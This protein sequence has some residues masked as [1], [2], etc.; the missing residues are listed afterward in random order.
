MFRFNRNFLTRA[1][2]LFDRWRPAEPPADPLIA[3]REPKWRNPGGRSSGVAV[4]E[5]EPDEFVSASAV[6]RKHT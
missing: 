2:A 5:P 6:A 4:P 3:V 1:R